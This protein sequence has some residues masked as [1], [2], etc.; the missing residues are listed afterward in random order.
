MALSGSRCILR[1]VIRGKVN[2]QFKICGTEHRGLLS[3]KF[4][5][6]TRRQQENDTTAN[7]IDG[8]LVHI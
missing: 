2:A 1:G 5:A 4:T 6:F 3:V 8:A 7:C